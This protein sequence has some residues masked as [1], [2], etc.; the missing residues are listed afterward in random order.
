MLEN[1]EIDKSTQLLIVILKIN[2]YGLL[3]KV[4]QQFQVLRIKNFGLRI[5]ALRLKSK[6]FFMMNQ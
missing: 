6:V 5:S 4:E 1:V 2:E 3:E